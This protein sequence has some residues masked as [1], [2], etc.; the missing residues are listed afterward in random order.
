[1]TQFN[2]VRITDANDLTA[3]VRTAPG[4]SDATVVIN[5]GGKTQTLKVQLG[6]LN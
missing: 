2:G 1:M 3:Q 4:G 6:T 5:R